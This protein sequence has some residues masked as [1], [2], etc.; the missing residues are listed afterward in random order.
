MRRMQR[1]SS[2]SYLLVRGMWSPAAVA[3]IR[4]AAARRLA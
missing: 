1:R 4:A 3:A 2:A